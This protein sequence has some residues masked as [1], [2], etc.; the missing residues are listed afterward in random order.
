[1]SLKIARFGWSLI[2]CHSSLIFQF[3][4]KCQLPVR[5]NLG[6]DGSLRI[7]LA[8][9]SL[10]GGGRLHGCQNVRLIAKIFRSHFLDVFKCDGIHGVIELLIKIEA[11]AVKLV[12]RAMIT[13]SVIAL[14]GDFLLAD[15]FLFRAL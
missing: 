15:Q 4:V 7:R 2:T 13:E 11:E 14:I 1:M 12:E 9:R 8:R 3:Y 10:G 6:V 5:R